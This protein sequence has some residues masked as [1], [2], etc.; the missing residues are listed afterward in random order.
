MRLDSRAFGLSAGIVAAV[1][2]TLCAAAVTLLPGATSAFFSYIM[3]V[4]V[5]QLTMPITWGS[6]FGGLLVWA[7]GVGV[8]FGGAAVLYN[9]L[10]NHVEA[11][12]R[13]SAVPH[14]AS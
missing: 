4:D 13:I 5:T 1:L 10:A 8:V 6:F 12:T 11:N 3:H 9:R 2:F 14:H 7:I